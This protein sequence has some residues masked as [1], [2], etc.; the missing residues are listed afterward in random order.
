MNYSWSIGPLKISLQEGSLKNVVIT[1]DWRRV[2]TQD[3]YSASCYGQVT[4]APPNPNDFTDFSK[5]TQEQ[6]TGWVE[7]MLGPELI[8]TYNATLA[9]QINNQI[10]PTMKV[11]S[12]P[13][14]AFE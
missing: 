9:E 11:V 14:D 7:S 3:T 13:W 8:A 12:P 10:N 6:V 1:V 2:C 5:L 4:C